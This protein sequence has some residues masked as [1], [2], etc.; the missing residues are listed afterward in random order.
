MRFSIDF[1][2]GG[3]LPRISL[4]QYVFCF[5]FYLQFSVCVCVCVCVCVR[6]GGGGGIGVKERLGGAA[7][8]TMLSLYK[9]GTMCSTLD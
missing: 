3:T 5:L 4:D 7:G 8:H 6:G 9:Q 2:N 1:K